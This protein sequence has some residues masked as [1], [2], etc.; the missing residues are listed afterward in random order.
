MSSDILDYG[1]KKCLTGI[2]SN[3]FLDTIDIRSKRETYIR[4]TYNI[5]NNNEIKYVRTTLDI[6]EYLAT[7]YDNPIKITNIDEIME[8]NKYYLINN[9]NMYDIYL[10]EKKIVLQKGWLYTYE[11]EKEDV[12]KICSCE[13]FNFI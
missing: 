3:D 7:I 1:V 4:V 11:V 12:V 5:N 2:L 8:E 10:L 13:V 9:D 6:N